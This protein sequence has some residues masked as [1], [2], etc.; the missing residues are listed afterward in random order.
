MCHQNDFRSVR[1]L[2]LRCPTPLIDLSFKTNCADGI[3]APLKHFSNNE[4]KL[5]A[6]LFHRL[7][8]CEAVLKA[9][10]LQTTELIALLSAQIQ[11]L[12]KLCHTANLY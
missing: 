1:L 3:S 11:N 9:I 2:S 5:L 8:V 4:E 12:Q 10:E 6:M 7:H